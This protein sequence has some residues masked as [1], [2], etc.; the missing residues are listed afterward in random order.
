[1]YL[2]SLRTL[3][4]AVSA[5]VMGMGFLVLWFILGRSSIYQPLLRSPEMNV[6]LFVTQANV[7][8]R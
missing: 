6:Q 5:A 8:G 4:I 7:T 2:P 3:K 1:M